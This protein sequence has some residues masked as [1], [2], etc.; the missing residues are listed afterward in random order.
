MFGNWTI[1]FS[2]GLFSR[3]CDI[4]AGH[5]GGGVLQGS[6]WGLHTRMPVVDWPKIPDGGMSDTLKKARDK[7]SNTIDGSFDGAIKEIAKPIANSHL[8]LIM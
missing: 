2:D 4:E 8:W 7:I 1:S 5:S 6:D 3:S